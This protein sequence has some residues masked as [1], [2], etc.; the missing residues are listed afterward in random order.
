MTVKTAISMDTVLFE[1][2][3]TMA[4]QMKVSRSRLVGLAL[5]EFIC[6]HRNRAMLARLNAVY[7]DGAVEETADAAQQRRASHRRRVEGTW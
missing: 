7:A 1:Q 3:E 5:D 2:A 4:R 6:R